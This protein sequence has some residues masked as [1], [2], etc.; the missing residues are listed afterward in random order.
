[1]ELTPK[2]KAKELGFSGSRLNKED[3]NNLNN[4]L[5]EENNELV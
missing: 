3:E 5:K 2:Q 1:M 4:N